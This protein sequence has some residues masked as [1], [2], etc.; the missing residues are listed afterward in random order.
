MTTHF[1][2]LHAPHRLAH[3][4]LDRAMTLVL[5][6]IGV[7]LLFGALRVVDAA[8]SGARVARR[9]AVTVAPASGEALAPELVMGLQ[10]PAAG[11]P[12]DGEGVDVPDA[13]A[14]AISL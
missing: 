7:S 12:M 2:W 4:R 13:T 3:S 9:A 1:T 6:V 11:A 8:L 10:P 5:G 14:E